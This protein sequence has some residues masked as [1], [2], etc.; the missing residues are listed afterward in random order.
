MAVTVLD[1]PGRVGGHRRL[2]GLG[3]GDRRGDFDFRQGFQGV[4]HRGL[5]HAHDLFA[6]LGPGLLDVHLD[7]LDGLFL[8]QD[9]R[10]GE[11]RRL[12]GDVETAAEAD[13]LGHAVTVQHVKLHLFL[14]DLFL[15]V[16]R[17]V[18]PHLVGGQRAVEQEGRALLGVFQDV[19]LA[20]EVVVV[21]GHEVGLLNE[22]GRADGLF[23]EPQVA[24]GDGAG[25][26]ES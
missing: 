12:Q 11:E 26:L 21:A 18:V 4:V 24:D 17:Q 10:Q 1:E 6:L 13:F 15:G 14:D 25:F 22:V 16:G 19:V 20:H 7:V 9:V 23:A 2:H 3:R 5:V 8:G